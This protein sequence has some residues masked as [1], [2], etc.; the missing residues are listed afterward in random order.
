M[1]LTLKAKLWCSARFQCLNSVTLPGYWTFGFLLKKHAVKFKLRGIWA[2]TLAIRVLLVIL[3]NKIKT[4][5]GFH[6][7]KRFK[8]EGALILW[9]HNCPLIFL[10]NY[11]CTSQMRDW[12]L[13][14][15]KVA[16]RKTKTVCTDCSV[17]TIEST[18][19]QCLFQTCITILLLIIY[20]VKMSSKNQHGI[21]L[22][23][24][25][26]TLQIAL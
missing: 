15:S 23:N 25:S 12:G 2:C 17:Q 14:V 16:H 1:T 22:R 3:G 8:E 4:N 18:S 11:L 20:L 21:V 10:R 7:L 5:L 19:L 26:L 6:F 9:P 13:K 24:V